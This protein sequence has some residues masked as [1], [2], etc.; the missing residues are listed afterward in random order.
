MCLRIG[1]QLEKSKVVTRCISTVPGRLFAPTHARSRNTIA[2]ATAHV[3]FITTSLSP[4]SQSA[5][6]SWL[7]VCPTRLNSRV[8]LF[9][10]SSSRISVLSKNRTRGIT[11]TVFG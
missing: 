1:P 11:V 10:S 4:R 3:F 6:S 2:S 9:L 5:G 7:M 8:A